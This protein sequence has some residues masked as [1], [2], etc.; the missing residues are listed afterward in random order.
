MAE[1]RLY[2]TWQ[3]PVTPQRMGDAVRLNDVQWDTDGTTLVWHERRPDGG[4]LIAQT[5]ADAPRDLTDSS[6]SVSGRVGYGGGEFTVG[7]G[8][9]VFVANGRLY[10]MPLSDGQPKPLTP[11]YGGAAAP[12]ISADGRWVAYVHTYEGSDAVL[13]VDAEG[14][15]LP[16][17]LASGSD[18]VIQ[19]AWHPQG[20]HLAYVAWN[21]PHMPWNTTELRL[22]TLAYDKQGNPYNAIEETLVSGDDVAVFQPLFSPD[23]RYLAYVSDATGWGHVYLYDLADGTHEQLTSGESEHGTPN[24]VQGQRMLSWAGD[25]RALYYTRNERGFCSVWRFDLHTRSHS[26]VDGLADYTFVRQIAVSGKGERLALIASHSTRPARLVVVSR[27]EGTRVVRRTS[28]ERIKPGDLA[29]AEAI[30]WTSFDGETAHGLY[31]APRNPAC[32]GI[33]KPPL[34]VYV[35]GGPTSQRYADYDDIVQFFATRGYAVLQVNHR[36]STGY[37]KAYMNKQRHT[38][39]VHDVEDSRTGALHLVEKGLADGEKLVIMGG[40]AGGFTVLM[41]L[42]QYPGV[43]RAGVNLYGVANQFTIALDASFKFESRYFEWLLG[44]ITENKARWRASSP[45]FDAHKIRDAIIIFQGADDEVVPKSQSDEIVAAL[46]RNG[47]TH[48]Y[49]VY[50]GEGHGFG[51]AATLRDMYT[52]IERFLLQH[53]IYA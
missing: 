27:G 8:Q 53:V 14:T 30:E 33:G 5:N 34:L 23:G 49:H 10:T 12:T 32:E 25:G 41:M 13:V 3:S 35:H 29:S 6:L 24:W 2:G 40:S 21:F 28:T 15:R 1:K 39:G 44:P 47:V 11:Q 38:W 36:G 4:V 26:R 22:I 17:K 19:P 16:Q 48:E 46:R 9:V 18:F 45:V 52:R 7:Q 51:K 20:T 50:E 42:T 43:F 31:Y 37:G